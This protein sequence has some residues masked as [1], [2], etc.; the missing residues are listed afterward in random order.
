PGR[1]HASFFQNKSIKMTKIERYPNASY[2]CV[3]CRVGISAQSQG[4]EFKYAG[5]SFCM[6]L[7]P[8]ATS[9]SFPTIS[10]FA[11]LPSRINVP[12][13]AIGAAIR[14]KIHRNGL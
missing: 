2:N 9:V 4:T 11:K 10:L 1:F 5:Q 14:S 8:H 6:N 12:A 7:T 13:M 3:A